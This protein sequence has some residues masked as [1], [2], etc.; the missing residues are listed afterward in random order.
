MA[1][2]SKNAAKIMD[3]VKDLTV[4]VE[5]HPEVDK[6]KFDQPKPMNQVPPR[7]DQGFNPEPPAFSPPK[8]EAPTMAPPKAPEFD[9]VLPPLPDDLPPLG[10]APTPPKSKKKL[11]GF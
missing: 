7:M 1:E 3:M 9:S 5:N 8:M 6:P 10:P 2:L 11:F 4:K